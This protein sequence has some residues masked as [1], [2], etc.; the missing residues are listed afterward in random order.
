M[1]IKSLFMR[2]LKE[3]I[4]VDRWATDYASDGGEIAVLADKCE[5][6]NLRYSHRVNVDENGMVRIDVWKPDRDTTDVGKWV[7]CRKMLANE[8]NVVE[9]LRDLIDCYPRVISKLI[10]CD[11]RF[12]R[13]RQE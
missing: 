6:V 12:S 8:D 2:L 9:N 4:P 7:T 10:K 11:W 13:R 3:R 5:L 1:T